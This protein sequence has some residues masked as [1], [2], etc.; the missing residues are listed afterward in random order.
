MNLFQECNVVP[1]LEKPNR[2]RKKKKSETIHHARR[3]KKI[4]STG[5]RKALEKNHYKNFI[6]LET[7]ECDISL[8]L[9]VYKIPTAIIILKGKLLK[10]Y[11]LRSET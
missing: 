9:R 6:Q 2:K 3:K 4:F 1:T 5:A 10:P 7:E 8:N 11:L